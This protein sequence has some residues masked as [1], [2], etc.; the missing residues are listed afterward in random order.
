MR[1]GLEA[2]VRRIPCA[3]RWSGMQAL[4]EKIEADAAAR[5]PLPPGRLPAQELQRYKAF[6]KVETHRLKLLHR[7]GGGGREVCQAPR[8]DPRRAAALSLGSRQDQPVRA[9]AGRSFR[10]WRWWPSA[11]TAAAELNPH[12][13]ID[14]MFLHSRPG[15]RPAPSP[16][17]H[18]SQDHRRHPVSA[19]G[20]RPEGWPLGPQHRGL[21]QGRQQ[22]HAIQDLADRGAADHGQRGAVQRFQKTLWSANAWPATRTGIHRHAPGGPGRPARQ[23]RQLRLHAGAQPQERLRRPARLPEPALDGVLQVSHRARSRNCRRRTCSAKAERKQLEA[24]YDFLLRVRT[25]MHYHV[26]RAMDVLGKNL[27]PA[28]A[29]N[30]GYRERSPSKRIEGF[31]RDV[32]IHSRN[33]FLITRTLEQRLAP[34]APAGTRGS[35]CRPPGSSPADASP[36]TNRWTASSSSTAK[37]TP[38]PTA[39]SATSRAG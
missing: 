3:I 1:T 2:A 34:A 36:S 26:N 9:G 24:A 33:I 5:L 19:V 29:H 25:E 6:L 10:R 37:S 21:R 11:A 17:P 27:Q 22:R 28:V 18:L 16:L 20:H 4:L 12:S 14:F 7:A 30:L 38:P 32:Y 39:S 13:D 23:V 15:G 31:M 8:D 35:P